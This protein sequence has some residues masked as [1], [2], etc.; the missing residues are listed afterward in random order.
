MAQILTRSKRFYF[1]N[2]LSRKR[3]AGFLRWA[4]RKNRKLEPFSFPSFLPQVKKALFI[5]PADPACAMLQIPTF[6]AVR[7]RLA[8]ASCFLLCTDPLAR[9]LAGMPG[10]KRIFGYSSDSLLLFSP[11]FSTWV[12][13][14][15]QEQFD[16]CFCLDR[17]LDLNRQT[18]IAKAGIPVRVGYAGTNDETFFNLVI[19]PAPGRKQEA[20]QGFAFA[21]CMGFAGDLASFHLA[22]GEGVA[23]RRQGRAAAPVGVSCG[24]GRELLHAVVYDL[25]SRKMEVVLLH[26]P[27]VE[28]DWGREMESVEG[29]RRVSTETIL[30]AAQAIGSCRGLIGGIDPLVYLGIYMQTPAASIMKADDMRIWSHPSRL[31]TAVATASEHSETAFKAVSA[32]ESLSA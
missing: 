4:G 24:L 20:E 21:R 18:L 23:A 11:P 31:F 14:I 13:Q 1:L 17:A 2:F 12:E 25:R 32:L 27:M 10:A 6:C 28:K 3:Q 30:D 7:E 19:R 29:V 26:S 22:I 9:F 15:K 5:L 8:G 16:A